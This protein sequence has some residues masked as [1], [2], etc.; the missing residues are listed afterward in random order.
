MRGMRVFGAKLHGA[1]ELEKALRELPKRTGRNAMRRAFKTA[2][3]PLRQ[4]MEDGADW[5]NDGMGRAAVSGPNLSRRQKREK[6]QV[7]SPHRQDWYVGFKPGRLA[8]L[9]ELGS[10]PRYHES[11]H[12]TGEMPATPFARPAWER[13]K[14]QVLHLFAQELWIE[15]GKAAARLARKSLRAAKK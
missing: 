14:R 11:G 12:F 10:A 7:S 2:T 3:E 5:H 15:I 1:K 13:H 8:H 4:S 6:K 9:F